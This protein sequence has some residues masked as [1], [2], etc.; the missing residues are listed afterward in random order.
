[1]PLVETVGDFERKTLFPLGMRIINDHSK[2]MIL[3]LRISSSI[4]PQSR[5]REAVSFVRIEGLRVDID[6]QT[7]ENTEQECQPLSYCVLKR[8]LGINTQHYV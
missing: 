2:E 3:L 8:A 1:M 4:H 6:P 5:R 7:L